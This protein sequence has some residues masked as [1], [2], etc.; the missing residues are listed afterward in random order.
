[1]YHCIS[2]NNIH[3]YIMCL[4]V[5]NYKKKHF[6]NVNK[7]IYLQSFKYQNNAIQNYKS[8]SSALD[9]TG[10]FSLNEPKCDPNMKPQTAQNTST[11][12]KIRIF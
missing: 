4:Y 7:F 11:R 12:Q 1:M 2:K 6:I 3:F 5:R 8:R 10:R 9:E